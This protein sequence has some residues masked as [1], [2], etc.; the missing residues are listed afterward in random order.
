MAKNT[1][2]HFYNNFTLNYYDAPLSNK[3][4]SLLILSPPLRVQKV[5]QLPSGGVIEFLLYV[6][7]NVNLAN[8]TIPHQL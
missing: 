2:G 7:Y 1:L 8:E 5:N 4:P 6:V 3:P